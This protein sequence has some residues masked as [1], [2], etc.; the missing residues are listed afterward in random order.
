MDRMFAITAELVW[1]VFAAVV[2]LAFVWRRLRARE[3]P[4][5]EDIR[6]AHLGRIIRRFEEE[7][8]ARMEADGLE[9]WR[10]DPAK[11]KRISERQD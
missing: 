4:R 7:Q 1:W 10:P 6:D 3:R 8:L 9:L 5:E 11:L 2:A